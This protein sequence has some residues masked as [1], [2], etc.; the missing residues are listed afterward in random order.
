[1]R[2]SHLW[3]TCALC[4]LI[5][6]AGFL[7][8]LANDNMDD[9]DSMQCGETIVFIGDTKPEVLSKCGDPSATEE[10]GKIW[11]YNFGPSDFVY[12]IT[13]TQDVVERIQVDGYGY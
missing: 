6:G 13:F 3:L 10:R 5:P 1:M 4:F 12:Y 9:A 11:I 7:T 2:L 8:A